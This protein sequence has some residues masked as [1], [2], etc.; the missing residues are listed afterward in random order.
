MLYVRSK[1]APEMI[2]MAKEVNSKF[3]LL[4]SPQQLLGNT[5]VLQKLKIQK[6]A[7]DVR[8][9]TIELDA[10]EISNSFVQ[11]PKMAKDIL[12]YFS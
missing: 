5:S 4:L 6:V 9:E 3:R 8:Y 1:F 12:I 10:R 7:S 2:K 11:P